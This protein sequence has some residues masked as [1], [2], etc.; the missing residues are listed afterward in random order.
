MSHINLRDHVGVPLDRPVRL[1]FA[2][3]GARGA[4]YASLA[5]E[6][7]A[8][9]VAVAEPRPPARERFA[10]RHARAETFADWRDLA[11]RPRLADAVVIANMDDGHRE[12]AEAF[13]ALGY[14]ILLEKPIATSE[15][16]VIAIGDAARKADVT[17]AVCHVMRY[18]RYTTELMKALS[19]I[20]EIVSVEHL[21]PIGYYH[22]AHSYVRGNWRRTDLTSSALLTKCCHD[23]DWLGYVIGRPV[24]RV[25]SF[26]SLS[27]FRPENRPI[28]AADRCVDCPLQD[29]CA[30]SA[31]RMYRDGLR[32]GGTRQYFTRIMAGELTEEAV[33]TALREGPYG[34]CV[35]AS[36]ND[37]VDHQI[38][39]LEYT[40]GVTVAFTMTAFTPV[41]HRH[42]KIFGTKGQLT[43]D[44]RFI[45]TYEFLTERTTT[46]DTS[47]DG[48][49][50]AEGHAGGDEALIRSFVTALHDGHP[51]LIRSGIDDSVD[52]HRV[53]FAAERARREGTVV[54]L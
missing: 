47:L 16:D 53:V 48:S 52:G 24:H 37:A 20:G 14:D 30:Y 54:T 40:G 13:A 25:S 5:E 28:D 46:I 29:T 43:G 41:E 4:A 6:A 44:G 19:D 36:D 35:W 17:L 22:F 10:V 26:G 2:G 31:T 51:D 50:A 15:E 42:T 45:H 9:V 8:A 21:E 23:I 33:T 7:G 32:N 1:A 3:A 12:A 27:Y 39:N 34:R 18:T 11:A 38:V 49:S